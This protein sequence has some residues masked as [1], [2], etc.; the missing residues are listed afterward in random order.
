[1]LWGCFSALTGVYMLHLYKVKACFIALVLLSCR[2]IQLI[3]NFIHHMTY[4]SST[5]SPVHPKKH[6]TRPWCIPWQPGFPSIGDKVDG[7]THL[8]I[9]TLFLSLNN[10]GMWSCWGRGLYLSLSLSL[11]S[12][13]LY[14]ICVHSCVAL[15]LFT[16]G[17]GLFVLI[18]IFLI[19]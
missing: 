11:S 14:T 6:G 18:S 16:W 5:C 9:F 15:L 12:Y 4:R 8:P 2:R 7:L 13:I 17:W 1:M 19:C 3:S 10:L